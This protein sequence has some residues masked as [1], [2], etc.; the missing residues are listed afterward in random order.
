[1][2]KLAAKGSEVLEEI[3][4]K[5]CHSGDA[6]ELR[7]G[8]RPFEKRLLITIEEPQGGFIQVRRQCRLVMRVRISGDIIEVEKSL[9][10]RTRS[11][12]SRDGYIY[13]GHVYS[14]VQH[15][16]SESRGLRPRR[17][18]KEATE[19]SGIEKEKIIWGR[20]SKISAD[21]LA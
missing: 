17:I 5:H 3:N 20:I 4:L 12:D 18:E 11:T 2:A 1:M 19:G 16:R 7:L 14:I 10:V 21:L 15:V 9:V 6:F 8:G 13:L